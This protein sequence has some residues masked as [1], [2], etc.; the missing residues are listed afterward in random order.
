MYLIIIDARYD[1]KI[2]FVCQHSSHGSGL[3]PS[4]ISKTTRFPNVEIGDT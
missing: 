2:I 1:H 4:L 3:M